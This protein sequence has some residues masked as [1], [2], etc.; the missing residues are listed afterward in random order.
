MRDKRFASVL[1]CPSSTPFLHTIIITLN[2]T[3]HLH[4]NSGGVV[5]PHRGKVLDSLHGSSIAA[6]HV[7]FCPIARASET[8]DPPGVPIFSACAP[9]YYYQFLFSLRHFL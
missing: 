7:W 9:K 5:A 2:Y 8:K 4:Q 3:L 1:E 6:V